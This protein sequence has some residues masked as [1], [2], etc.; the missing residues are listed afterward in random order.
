MVAEDEAGTPIPPVH[1]Q[2]AIADCLSELVRN[3]RRKQAR[4]EEA[5]ERATR[6][7]EQQHDAIMAEIQRIWTIQQV[8]AE[9]ELERL[10]R[11]HSPPCISPSIEQVFVDSL[12]ELLRN[13]SRTSSKHLMETERK[14]RILDDH[15]HSN[16]LSELQRHVSQHHVEGQVERERF[17]RMTNPTPKSPWITDVFKNV[18]AEVSR[19]RSLSFSY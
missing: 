2:Q 1:V 6:I 13:S 8:D 18:L 17:E 12:S 4:Q 19:V 7:A 5:W 9:T 16:V 15:F 14:Q 10:R 11:I 3:A